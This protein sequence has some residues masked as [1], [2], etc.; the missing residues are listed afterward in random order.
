MFQSQSR[1]HVQDRG[2]SARLV[3]VAGEGREGKGDG[4][5]RAVGSGSSV[6]L[7]L[8]WTTVM[9]QAPTGDIPVHLK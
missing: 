1:G 3:W 6:R 7:G 4:H 8:V 2:C 5:S 9:L